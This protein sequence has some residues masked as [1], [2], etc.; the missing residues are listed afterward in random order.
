MNIPTAYCISANDNRKAQF[1]KAWAAC[2]LPD[3]A[4]VDFPAI[5]RPNGSR[6]NALSQ[7]AAVEDALSKGLIRVLIFE[8]DAV[9]CD[10]ISTLLQEE[11]DAAIARGD[12]AIR[13]GWVEIPPNFRNTTDGRRVKG[14]HAYA[15]LSSEAMQDFINSLDMNKVPNT[16]MRMSV[17]VT[18]STKCLFVQYNAPDSGQ[19]ITH[20]MPGWHASSWILHGETTF[21]TVI[22]AL[23]IKERIIRA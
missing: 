6:G 22:E 23:N 9:P 7:K 1:H 18:R 19:S 8:D 4:V 16:F 11:L 10:N 14:S 2:G 3:E 21:N 5:T 15:L 12:G 20:H 17:P 13:L